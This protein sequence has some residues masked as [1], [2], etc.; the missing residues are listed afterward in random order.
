[1]SEEQLRGSSGQRV[2]VAKEVAEKKAWEIDTPDQEERG[3]QDK[4]SELYA[5]RVG[6]CCVMR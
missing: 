5:K 4:K 2:W 3:W 1:M 6:S